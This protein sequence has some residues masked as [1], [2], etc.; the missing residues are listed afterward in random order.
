M[1]YKYVNFIKKQIVFLL[2]LLVIVCFSFGVTYSNFIY[3]SDSHRAVEMFASSLDYELSIN[4]QNNEVIL[5]PGN[6]IIH[7]KLKSLNDV[8]SYYK[9]VYDNEFV[10]IKLY[11]YD[12][13]IIK[14]NE[15]IN[16]DLIV[17]NKKKSSNKL[18]LDVMGGYITKTYDDI[19]VTNKNYVSDKLTIGDIVTLNNNIFKLLSINEDGS[20]EL[21]CESFDND[22]LFSGPGGYNRYLNLLNDT[23]LEIDNAINIRNVSIEDIEKY[24]KNKIVEY[25]S[26]FCYYNAYYPLLWTMEEYSIINNV[27]QKYNVSRSEGYINEDKYELANSIIVRKI[28]INKIEFINKKYKE[29]FLDSDYLLATR[30]QTSS[31]ESVCFGVLAINENKIILRPLFESDGSEYGC[32]GKNKFIITINNTTDL[33]SNSL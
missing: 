27:S 5:K 4:N 17:Y 31:E 7:I 9:I 30:Y 19:K 23:S 29:L 21:I 14:S 22:I 15:E 13:N 12:N 8:D 11:N 28:I 6:N 24:T 10:N 25:G 33:F 3:N 16:F 26:S 32:Q 1:T 2:I 20:Y 18:T